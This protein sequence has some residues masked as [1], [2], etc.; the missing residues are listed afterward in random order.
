[1][2]MRKVITNGCGKTGKVGCLRVGV[3]GARGGVAAA[4]VGVVD[5]VAGVVGALGPAGVHY[6][7]C[8]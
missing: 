7:L 6:M 5:F 3:D 1:M 4:G 2:L 8:W